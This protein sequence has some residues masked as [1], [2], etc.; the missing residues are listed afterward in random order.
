MLAH[1]IAELLELIVSQCLRSHV[2][3]ILLRRVAVLPV[4]CLAR[5]IDESFQFTDRFSQHGGVVLPINHPVAPLVFF[6]QR[7][8]K[9]EVT[10]PTTSLPVD[11]LRNPTLVS[12]IDNLLEARDDMCMAMVPNSTIIQYRP[13]LWATAPVV[14]DPAKE[15][16][17]QSPGEVAKSKLV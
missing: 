12:A 4:N 13:I 14:P 3:E 8:C 6:Q 16:R 9:P 15:S 7:G 11:R 1:F 5:G 2:D 17:T 10:E